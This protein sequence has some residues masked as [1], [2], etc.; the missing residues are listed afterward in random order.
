M[1][2]LHTYTTVFAL[3]QA[4]WVSTFG[5]NMWGFESSLNYGIHGDFLLIE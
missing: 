1:S 4:F 2:M 3:L 5:F